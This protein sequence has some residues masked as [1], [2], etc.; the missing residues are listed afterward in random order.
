MTKHEKYLEKEN[1][2]QTIFI[3]ILLI[4][5]I[6]GFSYAINVESKTKEKINKEQCEDRGYINQANCYFVSKDILVC[7]M[8]GDVKND[9]Q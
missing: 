7:N 5:I 6:I 4:A 3:L 2:W 9:K 8:K 1:F